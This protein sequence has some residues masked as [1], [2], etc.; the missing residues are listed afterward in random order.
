ME[1]ANVARLTT[2]QRD[3]FNKSEGWDATFVFLWTASFPLI[4]IK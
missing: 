3:E 2:N 1:I 4:Q